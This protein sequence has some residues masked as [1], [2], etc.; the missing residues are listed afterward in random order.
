MPLAELKILVKIDYQLNVVWKNANLFGAKYRTQIP[1]SIGV[2]RS[3]LRNK[4]T[5][6]ILE[7]VQVLLRHQRSQSKHCSVILS[8]QSLAQ[9]F[10]NLFELLLK[11]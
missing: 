3:L 1:S 11:S 8:H 7:T 2:R 4:C 6:K 5:V 9:W 10:P